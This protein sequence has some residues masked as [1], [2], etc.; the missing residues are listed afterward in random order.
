[1]LCVIAV[2]KLLVVHL[3]SNLQLSSLLNAHQKAKN[4]LN[5]RRRLNVLKLLS[6]LVHFF[7][8][9]YLCDDRYKIHW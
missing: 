1:M 4:S 8:V 6:D 3:L 2:Q 7:V 5:L 9:N